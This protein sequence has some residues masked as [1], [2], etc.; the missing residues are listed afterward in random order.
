MTSTSRTTNTITTMLLALVASAGAP[1]I[2][3][4]ALSAG[5]TIA[6]A[7]STSSD[8]AESRRAKRDT[9]VALSKPVTLDVTD[10]PLV[11]LLS[12]ISEVTGAELEPIYLT[13]NIAANGMDPETPI[14]IKV[15]NTPALVVLE[16]VLLRAQRI[17]A[18][19]DEY[20]WQFTDIGTLE[21]GPK[22][23]LNRNQR[24][25]LYD[26]ADLLFVVPD[27][28]NA[29]NFNLQSAVAAAAGGGGGGGG[30]RSPFTGGTQRVTLAD[31]ADRATAITELIQNTIEP[32]QWAELGGDGASMT[33]YGNSIIVTA[34]DYVH[35]QI[36]G[37]SFWPSRLQ[38]VRKVD[39]KQK[40]II[41]PDTRKRRSP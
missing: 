27:F 30:G 9:L 37:Y 25:E 6:H 17:E 29:P 35:R 23:E 18:T 5:A 16:R 10:Q 33:I 26:L 4:A 39:G 3:I 14:T 40:V 2:G 41:K 13:D 28:Q 31:A 1:T 11:D 15:S 32:D 12:F 8:D 34:P 38:Q 21:L 36:S 24:V 7:Q 22:L 20:T 19:G